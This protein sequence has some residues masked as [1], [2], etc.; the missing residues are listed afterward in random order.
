MTELA[1]REQTA[2]Q[3]RVEVIAG[4]TMAIVGIDHDSVQTRPDGSQGWVSRADNL[5]RMKHH[6]TAC[7][8]IGNVGQA[9]LR[10]A[11]FEL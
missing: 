6:V 7:P 3:R 5:Q 1:P 8:Q 10:G 9:L 4:Q 2:R 11:G